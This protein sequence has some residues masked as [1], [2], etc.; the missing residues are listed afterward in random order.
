MARPDRHHDEDESTQQTPTGHT[1]PVPGREQVLHDFEKVAK[2][3]LAK[4]SRRRLRRP[5]DQ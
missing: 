2:A 1:I 3:K 4:P 5:K